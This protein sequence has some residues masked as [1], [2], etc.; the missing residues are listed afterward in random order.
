MF[1]NGSTEF[2][3]LK[4]GDLDWDKSRQISVSLDKYQLISK[5]SIVSTK[6]S[7][8]PSLNWKRLNLKISTEKALKF[9]STKIS[10][11]T[12]LDCCDP[13]A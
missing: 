8:Q 9:V 4:L 7:T 3:F 2:F 13:Q 1:D 11:S 5:I 10:I 12:S 6:I